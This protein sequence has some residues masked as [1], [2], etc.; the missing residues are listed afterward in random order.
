MQST[1]TT[2][3]EE[4]SLRVNIPELVR[5]AAMINLEQSRVSRECPPT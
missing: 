5:K 3:A 4:R 1:G 2:N